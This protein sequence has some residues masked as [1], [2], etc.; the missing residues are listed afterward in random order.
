MFA[1]FTDI[2]R[3]QKCR[4]VPACCKPLILAPR[5]GLEPPT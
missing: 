1:R 2:L 4:R 3:T 5:D